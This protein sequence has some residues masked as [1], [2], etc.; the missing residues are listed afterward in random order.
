MKNNLHP[1]IWFAIGI[2][3][4][5]AVN[6]IVSSFDSVDKEL[7]TT[8]LTYQNAELAKTLSEREE[9]FNQSLKVYK[10]L[11]S[12]YHPNFGNGKLYYNIANNYFQLG[13]Y[14]LAAVYYLRAE[15]LMPNSR[16]VNTNLGIT[17]NKL[18]IQ[19]T[20]TAS[21]FDKIFFFHSSLS[22]PQKLQAMLFVATL[23]FILGCCLIWKPFTG[24]K[25]IAF[26]LGIMFLVLLGS[27][28][29][30]QYLSP[31]TAVILKANEL[32]Q[33][34]GFQ[35]SKV[36]QAPILPGSEVTVL[37]VMGKWIKIKTADGVVGY[38]PS[39]GLEII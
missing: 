19:R 4:I 16:E 38:I 15:K 37:N 22:L 20:K 12:E 21:V 9:G 2:G 34:A 31:S 11:E 30:S 27:I 13:Q 33:D 3:F 32:Y 26:I 6:L 28:F 29:Y 35:Y 17:L 10:R 39:D 36:L 5:I 25:T 24:L 8:A 14:P 7:A 1:L 23:L 18:G